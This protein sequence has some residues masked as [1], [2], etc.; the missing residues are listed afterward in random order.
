MTTF[1]TFYLI[2]KAVSLRARQHRTSK[3]DRPS[4][5]LLP[6]EHAISNLVR[7]IVTCL[8]LQLRAAQLYFC[9]HPEYKESGLA[10][11][12]PKSVLYRFRE[13]IFLSDKVFHNNIV[14]ISGNRRD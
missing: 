3:H 13:D 1:A 2:F 9:L 4:T 7:I 14:I 10:D 6:H 11:S 8:T 12:R 5:M